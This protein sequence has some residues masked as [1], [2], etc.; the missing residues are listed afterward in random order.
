MTR[1][2]RCR[3]R[4]ARSECQRR[5]RSAR[6]L[7]TAASSQTPLLTVCAGFS[8]L[9]QLIPRRT[10]GSSSSSRSSLIST[11]GSTRT[12]TRPCGRRSRRSRGSPPPARA[13]SWPSSISTRRASSC[14]RNWRAGKSQPRIFTND[15]P[16]PKLRCYRRG[17]RCSSGR[18]PAAGIHQF[19]GFGSACDPNGSRITS[20]TPNMATGDPRRN[21]LAHKRCGTTGLLCGRGLLVET[22]AIRCVSRSSGSAAWNDP[23]G[24]DA[25]QQ[26]DAL[27]RLE[28]D[29]LRG[30][31]SAEEYARLEGQLLGDGATSTA[32]AVPVQ[33]SGISAP[34]P[35]GR[36]PGHWNPSCEAGDDARVR[37]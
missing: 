14:S 30:A 31:L 36:G 3:S 5:Y 12:R 13:P 22:R 28:S 10:H 23:V 15:G 7:S 1:R 34:T 16:T 32:P 24:M 37:G 8:E 26:R 20:R 11:G 33:A 25:E 2:C 21:S 4:P 27:A 17:G 18:K 35:V 6:A 9:E 29:Y 19:P